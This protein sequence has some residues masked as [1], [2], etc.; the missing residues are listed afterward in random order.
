[1]NDE[2]VI[3]PVCGAEMHR[4]FGEWEVDEERC[5]TECWYECERCGY[6]TY[7][8]RKVCRGELNEQGADYLPHVRG[9]AE[10]IRA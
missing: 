8:E 6:D 1:M 5:L 2:K 10:G 4:R 3:C 7:D 9:T